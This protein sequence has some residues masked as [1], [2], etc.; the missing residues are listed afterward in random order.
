MKEKKFPKQIAS[1]RALQGVLNIEMHRLTREVT[2]CISMGSGILS[3]SD[4]IDNFTEL[5]GVNL[6]YPEKMR[7]HPI[8]GARGQT[9]IFP[10][11]T[12]M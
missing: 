12:E 7:M 2:A 1:K 9:C 4:A 3:K 6:D 10:T 5:T 11:V 8:H